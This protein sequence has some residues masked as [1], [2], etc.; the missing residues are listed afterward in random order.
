[1]NRD[2]YFYERIKEEY[3]VLDVLE[4]YI[5][6]PT[7]G[8]SGM[9]LSESEDYI[10]NLKG[11]LDVRL[12]LQLLSYLEDKQDEDL[13]IVFTESNKH[14]R[15]TGMT[16]FSKDISIYK[17][18]PETEYNVDKVKRLEL[19]WSGKTNKNIYSNKMER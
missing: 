19:S 8:F 3:D 12:G 5:D 2:Y 16:T 18:K 17:K 10:K 13:R 4:G 14:N 11:R 1:M 9:N 6:I 15:D 7:D